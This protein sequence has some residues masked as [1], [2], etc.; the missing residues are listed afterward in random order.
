MVK[1]NVST[2][3]YNLSNDKPSS[4]GERRMGEEERREKMTRQH[5]TPCVD[6]GHYTSEEYGRDSARGRLSA[7]RTGGP[8][9]V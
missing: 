6:A 8:F 1:K 9:E 5:G 2:R 3:L 4:R 7:V